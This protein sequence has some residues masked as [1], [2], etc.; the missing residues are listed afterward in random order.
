MDDG[1]GD[2]EHIEPN[3]RQMKLLVSELRDRDLVVSK[4]AAFTHSARR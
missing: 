3:H 2:S 1:G 4:S